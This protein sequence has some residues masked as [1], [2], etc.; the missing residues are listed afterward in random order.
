M[1]PSELLFSR[2]KR[3]QLDFIRASIQ[4]RVL[5]RQEGQKASHNQR[6]KDRTIT[7]QSRV[8]IRNF[9][10]GDTWLPGTVIQCLERQSSLVF[11]D[12][13]RTARIDHVRPLHSRPSSIDQ[14]D[15]LTLP[16]DI[17]SLPRP[18][19][20]PDIP[21]VVYSCPPPF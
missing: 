17:P 15:W 12:D 3:S 5:A 9:A 6:A 7:P 16:D 2:H 19:P 18:Q 10:P 21:E 20:P 13:G 11:L 1:S 4:Q 8:L 14:P